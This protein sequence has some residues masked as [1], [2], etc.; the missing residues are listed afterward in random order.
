MTAD[1]MLSPQP[2]QDPDWTARYRRRLRA[3]MEELG[4]QADPI[5][6]TELQDLAA[7]REPLTPYDASLTN[8][9]A[10]RALNNLAWNL[11]TICEHAGWL[12]ATSEGGF[13]LAAD[14]RA[15]LASY[16]DPQDLY[17]AAVVAYR[18]WDESRKATLPDPE[19]DPSTQ[20]LHAGSG[21]VHALRAAAP[22]LDAWRAGASA[23]TEDMEVWTAGNARAL[24]DYLDRTSTPHATL[25]GLE[26]D[27]ARILAAEALALLTAPFSD[28]VGSTKRS[29]VRNPLV[30]MVDPPGLPLLM[31]AD[32][33][34]GFVHGGPALIAT[35][36]MMLAS[37]ARILVHWFAQPEPARAAA[38]N[39]P[40]AFR[41]LVLAAPDADPRIVSL[42]CL[43]AHPTAFTSVLAPA[44]RARIVATLATGSDALTDDVE[45][46]L[47]TITLRLQQ[48]TGGQ[49]VRYDVAPL[50]QQWRETPDGGS[51]AWLVR[52]EVDQQN[53]VP[54]WIRQGY[55]SITVG[56][57]TQLPAQVDQGALSS[58][59]DQ[60][61]G[62]LP[63]VKRETKKRDVLSFV[64]GMQPGDL[65]TTVDGGVLRLGRVEDSP[66]ELQSIGGL[67]LLTRRVAWYPDATPEVKQLP[68]TIRTRV[69]F[70]GEDVLDLTDIATP[71]TELTDVNDDLAGFVD[72]DKVD[73]PDAQPEDRTNVDGS[74]TAALPGAAVLA[75]DVDALAHQLHHA[76]SSWLEELL[77]SLNERKQVVLEG[78]PG[79]GKTFLVKRL[80]EA[81]DITEAQWALVQFH[82][83]YSY[84][85]FVEGFRPV[86]TP[87]SGGAALTV[88]PGPLKRIAEEAAKAPGKPFVLVIDE[89]NR[90]NI[91][92]VFGELY[93]LLEYRESE[94]EL[95]YS[96]GERFQMPENLFIIGTMNTADRSIALLD[97]AMR[98]RFVFLSMDSEEPALAGMLRRWCGSNSMPAA[99]ADLRDR[100]NATMLRR[101]LDPSL[102]FGPSYFMRSGLDS[103][104]ALD[105]L[106]RRELRPMLIE[107][108]Y[109]KHT[110]VDEWYPFSRWLHG[111]GLSAAPPESPDEQSEAPGHESPST[112]ADGD[113]S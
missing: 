102:A 57:L 103:P 74:D 62:H 35:P 16:P 109:G 70:K 60:H 90:A 86:Q 49:P 11:T 89:I 46:D 61:Y 108:H 45:R 87:D 41:D 4:K 63:V 14:G 51:R 75:C 88:R 44:E 32:L 93:Y 98:R 100:L 94:I 39:D 113:Q 26:P 27:E 81:C 76:D 96:D 13:R 105:R 15:A 42:V 54:A 25:P 10:V 80:L 53:R 34:Q 64:L 106:W 78:P 33:E 104:V 7:A 73:E 19:A 97:A 56:Q 59:V 79:T 101:G 40:W 18:E 3:A 36:L 23:F 107:H 58:L 69:R 43:V 72:T 28:M 66:A 31:S 2:E 50:L 77:V 8:S 67:S 55:V 30:P 17:D 91:A 65:V 83:T 52:G 6:L 71:L 48:E 92:K 20:V 38:W 82:P 21:T 29:R 84:E 9:G 47:R 24:R 12:H 112:T 110:Q 22:L 37:V 85:D 95:L 99:L 111:L 1:S 5:T 68:G